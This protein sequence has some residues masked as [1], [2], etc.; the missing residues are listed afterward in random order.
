M[1]KGKGAGKQQLESEE[2]E[3]KERKRG[4]WLWFSRNKAWFI[5]LLILIFLGS[6]IFLLPYLRKYE[7]RLRQIIPSYQCLLCHKKEIGASLH[8]PFKAAHCTSCHT[9]HEKGE[10]SKL[11]APLKTLCFSCHPNIGK[12]ITRNFVHDPVGKG[13]CLDCHLP[14]C[15]SHKAL[16]KADPKELCFYCHRF[17]EELSIKDTHQPFAAGLCLSCH[18]AHGSN[19]DKGLIKNQ[20]ILCVVCHPDVGKKIQNPCV[21]SPIEN[22][23]CTDCHGYHATNYPVQ[24][25]AEKKDFCFLCH[26]DI[27]TLFEKTS[28][29][30]LN[31]KFYCVNCH[32]PHGAPYDNLL[33][34]GG[35][36]FCFSCHD[37]I[38]EYYPGCAHDYLQWIAPE[39]SCLNCHSVHGS[40]YSLLLVKEPLALCKTCHLLTPKH[41]IDHPYGKPSID[42]LTGGTLTCSSSCHNPHN[43]PYPAMVIK[44]RDE[45]CLL[46]HQVEELP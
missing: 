33:S 13:F 31:E 12:D 26:K 29:H 30:P 7:P 8:Q 21:H 45:L 43:T 34:K 15:S 23:R 5:I 42:E 4:F 17:A 46:C 32:D 22:N 11:V 3:E 35:N 36:D 24:L 19:Y 16:L 27:K 38:G 9:P 20:K 41:R 37:Y 39:G 18:E 10:K 25:W 1:N 6:L 2:K 14:H 44:P 28:A 40:D